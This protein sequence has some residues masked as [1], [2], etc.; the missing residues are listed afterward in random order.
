MSL[1]RSDL[2]NQ[3]T[4]CLERQFERVPMM[5]EFHSGQWMHREYYVRHLVETV[6]RI[7]LNNEVDGYA[8]YRVGST[9]DHLAA[10]LAQYLAEEYGHEHM[11]MR[12]IKQLGWTQEQ[13]NA[14][15]PFFSTELLMG[16]LY[17]CVNKEGPAATTV[18]NYFVEWYSDQFNQVITNNARGQYGEDAL[19]GSQAHLDFDEGHDHD[20]LMWKVVDRAVSRWSTPETALSYAEHF[21]T[22]I[23]DYFME[24]YESTVTVGADETASASTAS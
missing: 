8:L 2:D 17:L 24:L 16:Y 23:G 15:K 11:F 9:D 1:Q 21:V 4:V 22:L 13:V 19:R 10:T 7:R 18:W 3:L 14:T 12:D 6:L 20:E 5:R